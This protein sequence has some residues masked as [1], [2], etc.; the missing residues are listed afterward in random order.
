MVDDDAFAVVGVAVADEAVGFVGLFG[1]EG[2]PPSANWSAVAGPRHL[3]CG[4]AV[5]R[6][7]AISDLVLL[8]LS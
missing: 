3:G 6:M 4:A 2:R 8:L 7:R 5:A 1:G